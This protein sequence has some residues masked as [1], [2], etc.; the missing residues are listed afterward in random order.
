[1][2]GFSRAGRVRRQQLRDHQQDGQHGVTNF[3]ISMAASMAG[4]VLA[5][6]LVAVCAHAH[7]YALPGI[8]RRRCGKLGRAAAALACAA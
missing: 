6:L 8:A 5:E 1:M 4:V 7:G 3:G 2:L